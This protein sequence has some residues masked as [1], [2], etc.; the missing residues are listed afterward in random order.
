MSECSAVT[1]IVV[2]HN[3]ADELKLVIRALQAQ[4]VN[5]RSILVID[6]AS[7]L[8]ATDIL[9]EFIGVEVIRSETNTGGAG[10]FAFGLGEALKLDSEWIWMMDDDAVPRPNALAALVAAATLL[11]ITTGA[12]CSAVYEFD[13]L[14][15]MH[16]RTFGKYFGLE[17]S[18][19]TQEYGNRYCEIDTGSFVGFMVRS[20]AARAVGLPNADFF[21]SYDDTEYSLRLKSHLWSVWLVPGSKIDHLRGVGSRLRGVAFSAKHFYNIRNRLHTA[22]HYSRFGVLAALV[23]GTLIWLMTKSPFKPKSINLFLRAIVDGCRGRLGAIR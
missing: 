6:N 12:L 11:P 21:L 23:V 13:A 10:G 2:T 17:L 7:S 19:P 1:A 16:R 18:I 4:T 14:A 20:V 5:L 9:K 22:R 3:R 15:P 8:P